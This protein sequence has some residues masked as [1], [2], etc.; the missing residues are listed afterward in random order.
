LYPS[1]RRSCCG[2]VY[3]RVV[4]RLMAACLSLVLLVGCGAKQTPLEPELYKP[5]PVADSNE[6]YTLRLQLSEGD[7]L[8][9]ALHSLDTTRKA[10]VPGSGE[11]GGTVTVEFSARV[12]DRVTK[13]EGGIY[14]IER[15]YESPIWRV[16]ATG[17]FEGQEAR[18]EEMRRKN[19]RKKETLR[20]DDRYR[21][22]GGDAAATGVLPERPIKEGDSWT[23]EIENVA[24]PRDPASQLNDLLPKMVHTVGKVEKLGQWRTIS[25]ES[26]PE[27]SSVLEVEQ[28]GV[29]WYDLDTGVIVQAHF[30]VN[31]RGQNTTARS[32][33]KLIEFRRAG[34][35]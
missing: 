20:F 19:L 34:A 10:V 13:V 12:V 21:P 26:R 32:E 31:A 4:N 27:E 8:V 33:L 18:I 11:E 14:T 17:E 7:T 30:N 16:A 23:T 22:V 9:Y 1:R 2:N 6:A 15:T 29:V 25:I 5:E 28:P 24:N 3:N 35:K